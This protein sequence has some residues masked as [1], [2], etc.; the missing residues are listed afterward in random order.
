MSALKEQVKT[1]VVSGDSAKDEEL[2]QKNLNPH[3]IVFHQSPEAKVGYIEQLQQQGHKVMM[4]G[5]GL[6]DLGAL[7]QA[8]VGVA[9]AEDVSQF[10]PSADV[11]LE[12]DQISN[13]SIFLRQVH[14][15]K[16]I[17][18]VCFTFS[19]LYNFIGLT[20]A[21]SGALS[22]LI[23]AVLMP[24]SSITIVG[25]STLVFIKKS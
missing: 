8:D 18:K 19:I 12:A 11:I 23:A 24:I 3:A 1:H 14:H 22:P 5:D 7:K 16:R 21:V 13:M 4:V 10:S 2:I 17:L 20:F 25:L 6:N 9:V 15:A